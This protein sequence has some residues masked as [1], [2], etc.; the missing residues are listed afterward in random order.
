MRKIEKRVEIYVAG[1]G[2]EFLNMTDCIFYE[3]HIMMANQKREWVKRYYSDFCNNRDK[4]IDNCKD[5]TE[6]GYK[7]YE[8]VSHSDT[9]V[10]DDI[11]MRQRDGRTI[12]I[13]LRTGRCGKAIQA[14]PNFFES[15]TGWAIAWA[16]YRGDEIPDYI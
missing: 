6:F 4:W 12:I 7:E 14:N 1:D 3:S 8:Y 15:E 13:N 16:R 9:T 2:K 5:F 10:C 11:L